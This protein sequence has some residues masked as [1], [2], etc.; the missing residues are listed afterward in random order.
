MCV[1]LKHAKALIMQIS[2]SVG[3]SQEKKRF[4]DNQENSLGK[5]RTTGKGEKHVNDQDVPVHWLN[6]GLVGG[7]EYKCWH[8]N[9]GSNE[10]SQVDNQSGPTASPQGLSSSLCSSC[11]C[12]CSSQCSSPFLS[13]CPVLS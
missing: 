10:I 7:L 5:Q 8:K 6:Q 4:W 2:S 13:P 9:N 3:T 11:A 12:P 1:S